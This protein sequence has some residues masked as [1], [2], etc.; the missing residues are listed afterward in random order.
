MPLAEK[1]CPNLQ[2]DNAIAQRDRD[3]VRSIECAEL[4]H[5]GM[6]VLIDGSS[7]YSQNLSD[8]ACRSAFRHPAENFAL[9]GR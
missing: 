2:I 9:S 4:A 3:R 1:C 8:L 7:R 6:H 5:R